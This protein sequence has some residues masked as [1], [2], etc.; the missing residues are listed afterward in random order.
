MAF[1]FSWH[2]VGPSG[3]LTLGMEEAPGNAGAEDADD[4]GADDDAADDGGADDGGPSIGDADGGGG[5]GVNV[6]EINEDDESMMTTTVCQHDLGLWDQ[7]AALQ[8]VQD[9]IAAFG[10]DPGRVFLNIICCIFHHH[11]MYFSS[12]YVVFLCITNQ[13]R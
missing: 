8:W 4:V 12:L 9:N 5:N 10:G 2:R 11:L 13:P 6:G 3:F 7:A 1:S